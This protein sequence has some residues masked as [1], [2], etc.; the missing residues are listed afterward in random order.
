M[1]LLQKENTWKLIFSLCH[2][3]RKTFPKAN[4][5]AAPTLLLEKKTLQGFFQKIKQDCKVNPC[6]KWHF[7]TKTKHLKT[8]SICATA[9]E[10]LIPEA[11]QIRCTK[12]TVWKENSKRIFRK[13][14]HQN[15]KNIAS[16][17]KTRKFRPGKTKKKH[18]KTI[19]NQ[20]KT[21]E[22]EKIRF[23]CPVSISPFWF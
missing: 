9:Q 8:S 7:S 11:N 5:C 17:G 18:K 3:T 6:V 13:M 2:C 4:Q 10:K 21:K 15:F 1:T 22:K 16:K 19:R 20:M 23:R 12:I 14:K